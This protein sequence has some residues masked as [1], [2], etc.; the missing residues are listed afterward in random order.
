MA[1]YKLFKSNIP[2]DTSSDEEPVPPYRRITEEEKEGTI[3]GSQIATT[4]AAS[5]ALAQANPTVPRGLPKK[6]KNVKPATQM[7]TKAAQTEPSIKTP[8]LSPIPKDDK[9]PEEKTGH[10]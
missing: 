10:Q 4:I 6:K 2:D 3:P 5:T 8:P 7:V 9:R 1:K